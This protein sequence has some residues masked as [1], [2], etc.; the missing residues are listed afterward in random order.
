MVLME[1]LIIK[2]MWDRLSETT[3]YLGGSCVLG[4]G[5]EF[6]YKDIRYKIV[7]PSYQGSMIYEHWKD[8]IKNELETI[9][10][11]EIYYN[12]GRMD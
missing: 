1:L 6:E 5:F 2:H 7:T 9:G 8:T 12:Y 3:Q 4:D 10:A 11:T